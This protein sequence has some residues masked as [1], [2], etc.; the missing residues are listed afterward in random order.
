MFQSY[1]RTKIL[2]NENY[3]NMR[4]TPFF[5]GYYPFDL[6]SE[7]ARGNCFFGFICCISEI[8]ITT[9][10]NKKAIG[11]FKFFL[12]PAHITDIENKINEFNKN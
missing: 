4:N 6:I 7:D 8:N 5:V 2:K 11:A 1:G 9:A 3:F 10:E 12:E